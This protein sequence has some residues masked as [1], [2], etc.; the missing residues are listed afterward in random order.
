[1]L[2]WV[3]SVCLAF[4]RQRAVS[5]VPL[6]WSPPTKLQKHHCYQIVIYFGTIASPTWFAIF[7]GRSVAAREG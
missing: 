4:S 1:M 5:H 3:K 7:L 6:L 2:F